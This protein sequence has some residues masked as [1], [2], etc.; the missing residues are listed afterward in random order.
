MIYVFYNNDPLAQDQGGG[1]EHFR[2]LHRA[3]L[4]SGL[5]FR[6][7]AARL[8]EERNAAHVEYISKGAAFPRFWLALWGW[9]WRNRHR[10]GHQD[11]FHFHRN[12]AAWPKYVLSPG[13]G[14][15]VITYH[16]VSGRVLA[17]RLGRWARPIRRLMLAFERRAVAWADAVICVSARDRRRLSAAVTPEPFR[18]AR[19]IPAAYDSGL[20]VHRPTAPPPRELSHRLLFL[21]RIS[22]QKNVGLAIATLETLHEKGE[23]YTLTI[24]GDGEEARDLIRRI[25]CSPARGAIRWLGR[26][27][28]ERVPELLANHGILLVTSRYEASPTV[29]KEALAA[30]RPVVSTDVGDVADWIEEGETGFIAAPDPGSLSIAVRRATRLVEQGRCR[31]SSRLGPLAEERIMSGV[32]QIYRQLQA[33]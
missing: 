6:L 25:N 30:I 19:I 13:R 5:P 9:F 7:V 4:K 14:R 1:A 33:S 10:I 3:L 17:G 27:P 21:G 18:N 26:V 20:F 2:S 29:V 24:A 16:N 31:R 28:H 8:Q 32:L 11:I 23:P 12:Y 22:H 15:V